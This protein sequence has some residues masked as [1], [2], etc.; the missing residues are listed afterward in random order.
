MKKLLGAF[1]VSCLILAQGI[2]DSTNAKIRKEEAGHSL[3]MHTLHMLA[4]RYGPRMTGTPNHEAAVQWVIQQFTEWGMKNAHREPWD[5]ARTGWLNERAAGFI[6]S[7]VHQNLKFEVVAWTPST[8]GAVSGSVVQLE[9][10]EG[11]VAP[12]PPTTDANPPAGGGPGARGGGGGARGG[13]RGPQRLGPT[14][15]EMNQWLEANKSKIR[16]KIVMLGKAAVVPVNFEPPA[17]RRPDDQVKA[18]YDPN[19]PNYGRGGFGGGA[20]GGNQDPNRMTATQV[21]EAVG[22]WLL[23]NGALVWLGDS[24]MEHGIIR[25]SQHHGY[26]STK[27]IPEVVLR[28]DDFGRIERLLADGEDVKAE[29]NIVNHDYPE[30]KTS[31]NVVGEIPGTDKADEIVMLGGHLDSWQSATGATD[32]GIGSSIMMEAARIIQSLGLKP[33]RTIRVALWSG[34]EEGLLGSLAYVKQHFGT[35]EDPKP[36]FAKLDCYFNIDSGTGRA[37]GGS[38]FGPPEAAAILRRALDP[39]ADLGVFGASAT[40]SRAT[41]GTDST[42]FNNAGLPGIGMSQDP[43]EYNSVTHHTN[44]DTYERIVPEDVKGDAVV[45]AASVWYVANLDQM[46]PRFTKDKMPA[47]VAPR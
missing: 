29:F 42:S 38:V 34:E 22:A 13:G 36:E 28:N 32:N 43:I 37:R 25:V 15:D 8:P 46:I 11:P 5:F 4:D 10:P 6:V 20:R 26:D 45:L 40:T 2:D 21:E 23:A 44:L 18:Q 17:L 47:P 24:P 7:P 16:G 31:Y 39:F 19:N 41:G 3:V 33:R 9:L 35:F 1:A 30:G 27:T 14:K 12:A